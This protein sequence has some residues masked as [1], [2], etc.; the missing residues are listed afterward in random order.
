MPIAIR[1][2]MK[3]LTMLLLTASLMI[4]TGLSA[5]TAKQPVTLQESVRRQLVTMPRYGVFDDITF[6]LDGSTVTLSGEVAQPIVKSDAFNTVAHVEGVT[7]VVNNIE[8]LPLSPTDD[9][10]RLAVYRSIYGSRDLADRY[11]FQAQPPIHII[12]KNG[13]VR[14]EGYVANS[15]DRII[16]GTR[17]NAVFGAFKVENNLK[18]G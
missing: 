1:E 17:A 11:A 16:A 3:Q 2:G 8:V 5:K 12:V 15:M 4:P 10:L 9:Q 13:V 7:N 18:V 14:L 6:R